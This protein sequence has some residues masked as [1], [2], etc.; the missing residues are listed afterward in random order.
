[1]PNHVKNRIKLIG[2]DNRVKE[3][4]EKYSTFHEAKQ[5]TSF[6]GDFT[7]TKKGDFGWW[8]KE[9]KIFIQRGKADVGYIPKGFT[10]F[11]E[12]EFTSMP[13]FKKV[14]PPPNDDAYN[15]LPNQKVAEKSPNWWYNWN[16]ENW[17]TKWSGYS[18]KKISDNEYEFQTAWCSVP[19][20]VEEM[21]NN[22]PDVKIEYTYADENS[23]YNCG[24]IIFENGERYDYN[25]EGGTKKAYDIYFE[26]NPD[27]K[28]Y[29][30]LVKGNYEYIE[31]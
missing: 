5:C 25:P 21:H 12:A 6:D 11:L 26:L 4:V 28:E 9:K 18:N 27:N 15:D 30:K 3:L 8:N 14:I 7:F 20:I 10:P 24:R 17:G 13:D 1:M 31:D 19:K 29:Y 16:L 2:N 22:F 23:G